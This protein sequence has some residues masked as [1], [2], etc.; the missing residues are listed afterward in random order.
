MDATTQAAAERE[1][2]PAW[3]TWMG[4]AALAGAPLV[5]T[6][7]TPLMTA[8]AMSARHLGEGQ[9][10]LV[11]TEELLIASLMTIALAPALS[12]VSLRSVGVFGLLLMAAGNLGSIL[13]PGFAGLLEARAVSG[14]GLGAV[15][16]AQGAVVAQSRRPQ[17]LVGALAAPI[18]LVLVA[19]SILAGRI[20]ET[21]G[22]VG[23]FGLYAMAAL[24]A[25]G[26]CLFAPREK[27]VRSGPADSLARLLR[28]ARS[29]FVIASFVVYIGAG[30]IWA[31][32]GRIAL[33]RG[34]GE[35]GVGDVIAGVT[36]IGGLC[37]ALTAII[38]NR[39]IGAAALGAVALSAAANLTIVFAPD[40][41]LLIG[42]ALANAIGFNLT[43]ALLLVI[44]AKLDRTGA[45]N[46]AGL[47]WSTLGGAIAPG[48]AGALI[49]ATHSFVPLGFIV[50][51]FAAATLT[52]LRAALRAM[53]LH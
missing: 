34:L 43:Q 26:M 16:A 47:G 35:A 20:A 44:G 10:G 7:V 14:V 23:P 2:G 13:A 36:V 28:M 40:A 48:L 19:I 50:A 1:T 30:S 18:T 45:L 25:A 53:P 8:T 4:Y 39:W 15:L 52:F 51:I 41:S 9:I 46:A 11:F 22:P 5:G 49:Q 31:F 38:V 42:G 12:N 24:V 27:Q 6:V 17:F 37:G 29:P 3:R 33:T 21:R 32:F